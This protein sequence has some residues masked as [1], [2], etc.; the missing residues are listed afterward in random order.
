MHIHGNQLDPLNQ[1]Y[2]LEEAAKS[3]AKQEDDRTRR[4]LLIAASSSLPGENEDCV[5]RLS[6]DEEGEHPPEAQGWE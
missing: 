4:K 1:M 3:A 5:V 2:A 6:G